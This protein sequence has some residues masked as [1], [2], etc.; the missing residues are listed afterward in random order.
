ML[1][2]INPSHPELFR[3]PLLAF[4]A[5]EP[6]AQAPDLCVLQDPMLADQLVRRNLYLT[7]ALTPHVDDLSPAEIIESRICPIDEAAA[8]HSP[9]VE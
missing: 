2:A 8:H 3:R 6:I 7:S 4:P 9:G 1:M 5:P